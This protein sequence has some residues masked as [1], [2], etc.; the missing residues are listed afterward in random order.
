MD[1]P[2]VLAMSVVLATPD[3]YE[4][5]RRTMQSPRS[6]I[7]RKQLEI[8]I[9][10]PSEAALGFDQSVRTEFFGLRVVEVGAI[11]STGEAFAAGVR[12]AAA[13]LVV[14]TEE[15]HCRAGLESAMAGL[16]RS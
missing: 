5:I 7:V 13:P 16:E 10:A 2:N 4:T 9:V 12:Q 8:V 6:Q 1:N 15:H 14:V 3:C 11:R